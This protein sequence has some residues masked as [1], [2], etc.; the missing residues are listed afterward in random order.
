MAQMDGAVSYCFWEICSKKINKI[1]VFSG[2]PFPVL[3][4]PRV[5]VPL[6]SRPVAYY[7]KGGTTP[8]LRL[9]LSEEPSSRLAF[10]RLRIF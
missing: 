5:S 2:V 6:N 8:R 1:L 10:T 3:A 7:R 9:A 4:C